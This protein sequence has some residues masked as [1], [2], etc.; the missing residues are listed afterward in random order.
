MPPKRAKKDEDLDSDEEFEESRDYKPKPKRTK[1]PV[2]F[3]LI[4]L[5]ILTK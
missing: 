3:Q 4:F 5:S 2:C 1:G